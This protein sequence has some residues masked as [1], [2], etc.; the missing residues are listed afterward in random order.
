MPINVLPR[1]VRP[2]RAAPRP[3][4]APRLVVARARA[5]AWSA[6]LAPVALLT[7]MG[8]AALHHAP[9]DP[10]DLRPMPLRPGTGLGG[11]RI[12]VLPL[13][14]LRHGDTFGWADAIT[15]PRD[16]LVDLNKQI[17]HALTTRVPRP[18]WVFP[19]ALVQVATRN[20]GYLS[21]PYGMDASQ[22]SPDHWR[23]GGKLEDP[24]AGDLRNYTAFVDARVA[25]LPVELRFLPRP[26]PIGHTVP[27]GERAVMRA[28][29]LHHMGRA[30]LRLAVVDTRTDDVMW[31]GDVVGDPAP[32]LTPAVAANLV[33]HLVQ[34]LNNE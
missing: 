21:D 11:D 7:L 4:A 12:I 8:C 17:E 3:C 24:L 5:V 10:V 30:V 2:R 19:P 29:S 25:L 32:A 27:D 23:P 26:I 16:Y 31:V 28:D 20:P 18:V 34:A 33:D 9:D 15:N 6:R 22:F 1:S 14:M 13:S